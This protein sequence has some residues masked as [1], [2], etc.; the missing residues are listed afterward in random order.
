MISEF[1]QITDVL[2]EVDKQLANQV[3]IYLIGGGMMLYHKLKI[4]TK[5]VDIVV[6]TNR[7][8]KAF[9]D[10]LIKIGFLGRI[11]TKE[12]SKV[13]L[14]QI[15]ERGDY[16]IDL[17]KKTV[18]K[19]FSLTESMKRRATEVLKQR[20]LTLY[21]CSPED[22]FM[23][24]TFTE[25][26]TDIDDCMAITQKKLN[27]NAILE[28]ITAQIKNSGNP[29]W[30]TWIGE[31]LD[32]LEEKGLFIPIMSQVNKLREAYFNIWEKDHSKDKNEQLN[33]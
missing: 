29:V 31:R 3:N 17:F 19:G 16:R 27:W 8:F 12:Y 4:I 33:R 11:P 10:A 24:K 14:S 21:L 26:D 25:R 22:I 9:E 1:K 20:H 15:L 30:I 13:D 28:E 7:E 23:F 5:D 18:C 2:E 32:I 6:E